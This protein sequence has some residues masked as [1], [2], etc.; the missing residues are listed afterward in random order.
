MSLLR[1][2]VRA[3]V[4]PTWF[5]RSRRRGRRALAIQANSA[6]PEAVQRS[7]VEAVGGLGGLDILV[8]NVGTARI[9]PLVGLSLANIEAIL[10]I[11]VR[12]CVL[13]TQA[14]L[15]HSGPI[16]RII[17]IGSNAA[18]RGPFPGLAVY[19]LSKSA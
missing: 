12:A 6:D 15:A 19:A 10:D 18:E 13:A 14:A 17:I 8:N 7:V 16:G 5:G 1:T 4:Q 11:N 9:G 3:N 2:I